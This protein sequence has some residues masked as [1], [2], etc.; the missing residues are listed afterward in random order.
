MMTWIPRIGQERDP[1]R[2]PLLTRT[3]GKA[4]RSPCSSISRGR[5][6]AV[7]CIGAG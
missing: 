6:A 5:K 4:Q 2:V 7:G 3:E 1:S